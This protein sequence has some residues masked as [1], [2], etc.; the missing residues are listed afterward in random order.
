M[1]SFP[2]IRHLTLAIVTAASLL[3]SAAARAETPRLDTLKDAAAALKAVESRKWVTARQLMDGIED[4]VAL[5]LLTWIRL[6]RPSSGAAFD[7]I[8]GFIDANPDWPGRERLLEHAE[9]SLGRG[10]PDAQV[11][12]WFENHP[13]GSFA[14]TLHYIDALRRQERED[15]AAEVARRYWIEETMTV[16]QSRTFYRKYEPLLRPEDHAARIDALLWKG[17]VNTARRTL[18]SL[19]LEAGV[20]ALANV[21]LLLKSRQSRGDK[22]KARVDKALANVPEA[23]QDLPGLQ[24]DLI[25]WHRRNERGEEARRMMRE[26][27]LDKANQERWWRERSILIRQS[28]EDGDPSAAY[29]VAR[30]H[31]YGSGLAFVEAEWLAG[32]IALR[33]L[34]WPEAA[35]LHFTRVYGASKQPISTARGAYWMG[36]SAEARDNEGWARQW[37]AEAAKYPTTFYGQLAAKRLGNTAIVVPADPPPSA[38]E[39]H[40][41][42]RNELVRAARLLHR[43]GRDSY[44]ETFLAGLRRQA[45]TATQWGLV[46]GLARELDQ[47]KASVRTAKEAAREGIVLV[48]A[49]YPVIPVTT[50]EGVEV[51]LV[52]ALI[53]QESEFDA[54]VISPAGARGLMQ[55]MPA[56]ARRTARA[57]RVKYSRRRL[58]RDPDYNIRLGSAHMASLVGHYDGSYVLTLAAYNAG[59]QRAA[60]WVRTFGDPRGTGVDIVDWIESIPFG[61]TRNYVQ[62]VLESLLTYRALFGETELAAANPDLW[63][64]P[65]QIAVVEDN[66]RCVDG[67]LSVADPPPC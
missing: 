29:D 12:A 48:S 59:G 28:L 22:G 47:V 41:F 11:I 31:V 16:S 14:G 7:E 55:L 58:T 62:R 35:T 53:R 67:T 46:A 64:P 56:T 54:D 65:L 9:Y 52:L 66:A 19:K 3:A 21:R 57:E 51:P 18:R 45:Q 40:A 37:Y 23:L 15:T 63:R 2:T 17:H 39:R 61:E 34:D 42:D 43:L 6:T 33:F 4:P 36:R 25:R 26:A 50:A 27:P 38:E 20:K 32:W 44:V 13:P 10:T 30:D 5:K 1:R 24:Y 49:G 8:S 60:S